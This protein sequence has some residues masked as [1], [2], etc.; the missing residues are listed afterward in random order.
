MAQ[1]WN[2]LWLT[3][4]FLAEVAALVALGHWGWVTGAGAV[5]LLL[6]VATPAVAGILWGLFA[7]PKAV[8]RIPALVALVK[9]L[10]FGSAVASLA[11]TGHPW[12]AVVLGVAAAAS[13]LL[14][15]PPV[16]APP[17]VSASVAG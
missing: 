8:V 16:A 12:T 4:A 3:V 5:G 9:V 11:V 1:A 13:A 14:S 17:V 10:V 2:W 7:A 6:A 15:T